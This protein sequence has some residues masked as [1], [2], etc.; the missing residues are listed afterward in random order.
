VT[1]NPIAS[2]ELLSCVEFVLTNEPDH[3]SQ[4]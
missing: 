2:I 4:L 1:N 3:C